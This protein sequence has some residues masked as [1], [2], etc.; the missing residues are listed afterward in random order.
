MDLNKIRKMAGL[1]QVINE[2]D[3]SES[4][5]S[6]IEFL[7]IAEGFS[8]YELEY[9]LSNGNFSEAGESI[10]V[11]MFESALSEADGAY[12]GAF[13][14]GGVLQNKLDILMKYHKQATAKGETKRIKQIAASIKT[15][16]ADLERAKKHSVYEGMDGASNGT[17]GRL[18]L[19]TKSLA[20]ARKRGA[21]ASTIKTLEGMVNKY[22]NAQPPSDKVGKRPHMGEF[23]TA[24]FYD[25]DEGLAIMDKIIADTEKKEA[26]KKGKK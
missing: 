1:P 10:L 14:D 6:E 9:A 26:S 21:D 8:V 20:A 15:T 2:S 25:A 4:N 12:G 5:N 19:A 17:S 16:K 23:D 22:K 7:L 3:N 18:A 13:H 24:Q 11:D